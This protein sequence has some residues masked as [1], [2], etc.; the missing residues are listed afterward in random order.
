MGLGVA[1]VSALMG[2][3]RDVLPSV[4]STCRGH[5]DH[6]AIVFL[7]LFLGWTGFG[8][9]ALVWACTATRRD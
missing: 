5:H 7:N 3:S 4:I 1:I 9:V 2:L 8:W 6:L